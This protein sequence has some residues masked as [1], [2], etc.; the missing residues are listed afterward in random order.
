MKRNKIIKGI[1]VII[2]CMY[3][4]NCTKD[5]KEINTDPTLATKDVIKPSLLLTPVLKN[6]IFDIPDRYGIGEYSGYF[7]PP[8]GGDVFLN[9]NWDDPFS[10]TYRNYLINIAEIMRLTAGKPSL[11]NENAIARIWKVWLF[12]RLTDQYGD[13]PY[14]DAV[15]DVDSMVTQPKYDT[16]QDIYTDMFKELKEAAAQLSDDPA[17]ESFGDAD[18]LFH[19][20]VDSWRRFANSLRLRLAI[21]VRYV[22]AGLAQAN[23]T[24]V[25]SQPLIDDNSQNATLSTLDDGNTQNDNQ[26]YETNLRLPGN[27]VVSFTLTDN[28]KRLN[29]PRLPAFA[30]PAP[31]AA[32]GYRGVPIQLKDT[33]KVRYTADSVS[34][35]SDAF[36][37]KVYDIVVLNAAEVDF[38]RSEAALAG[39]SG[40]DA[41]AFYVKGIQD[42]MDQYHIDPSQ[43]AAYLASPA[44]TLSGTDEDKLQQIITQKWLAI[45][46]D[47]EEAWA[48]FR[49]TGY[50][51]IWTGAM[52]GNTNGEVPRRLI[53]SN[54]EYF[55]N[56]ENV[57]AAAAR[58]A[59][60]D[61]YMS[62]VWWDVKPGLPFHHP[63][64][65]TFPPE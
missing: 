30:K 25:L 48:E 35:M 17:Q 20:D 40:E 16:Q 64:Q 19:G 4:M 34:L 18:I 29:D 46:Y 53:Y 52:L 8:D 28:L 57:K 58:L 33:Q 59:Q 36:L 60:G 44:G 56:T 31:A 12:H 65:G 37:Q 6:S 3:L 21:R 62:K 38:L 61:S 7:S 27:M 54:D 2:L 1:P 15:K 13:V 26:F 49:R 63:K 5:F 55:K 51:T 45:L 42:A 43:V 10:G 39:L 41:Q 9:I 22:D 50:P 32:A 14:F 24:D 47:P 23:I 11:S